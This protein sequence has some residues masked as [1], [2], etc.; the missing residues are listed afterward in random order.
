M[1]L[2]MFPRNVNPAA[3]F[4]KKSSSYEAHAFVQTHASQWL[5][6]WLPEAT[7]SARCLEFGAGT[8][9][10]T[11]HL[12]D[13]FKHVESSDIEPAMVE[14]C[15]AKYPSATHSVR[16]AW[17]AQP[18]NGG[19]WDLVAASSVLQ[20]AKE[21][22]Q[23]MRNWRELLNANGHILA[24][25]FIEPSLPEMFAVTGGESPLIWRGDAAWRTIF[26]SAGLEI[27]RM[28]SDERRYHY[29]SA[30]DFWK[31]LH[32]TGTAVS[33]KISPSQMMRFFRDY[34]LQFSDAQG[35]Y[36]TWTFCRVELKA[37]S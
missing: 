18:E 3:S 36:A 37:S 6:Q 14:L 29:P 35:V 28:E 21:P 17:A 22:V 10:M 24:G 32:S 5:A 4:G 2:T 9:L 31:S 25:F 7:D 30:L 11:G 15:E 19:Q 8:G 16:D 33:R 26:E 13:Q 12:V 27:V 34:E 23:V 1:P 20:W